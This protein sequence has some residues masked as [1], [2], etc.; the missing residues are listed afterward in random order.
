VLPYSLFC[1]SRSAA[2]CSPCSFL[3]QEIDLIASV[4]FESLDTTHDGKISGQDEL[5]A[6]PTVAAM[7]FFDTKKK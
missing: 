5:F 7:A 1:P 3:G 6:A 4:I 2:R